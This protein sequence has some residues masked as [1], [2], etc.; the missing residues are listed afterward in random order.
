[1]RIC[2]GR[3]PGDLISQLVAR[4]V[5]LISEL[6]EYK[7]LNME[8][9][10]NFD[11]VTDSALVQILDN[12]RRFVSAGGKVALGD[13]VLNF[14]RTNFMPVL[15]IELMQQAGMTPMQIL[16][17]GTQNAAHVCNLEQELGTLEVGKI[18]DILVVAGDP[19]QNIHA[20]LNVQLVMRSGVV[21]YS[22]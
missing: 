19:L 13:P 8:D 12:L 21:I 5:Y 1:M 15:E 17:A 2:R 11:Y 4:D 10:S 7:M 20:L 18:A 6:S 22:N 3:L 16:V 9:P 14:F